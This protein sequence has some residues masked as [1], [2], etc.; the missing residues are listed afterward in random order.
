M[1]V[2]QIPVFL[3]T[4]PENKQNFIIYTWEPLT[5]SYLRNSG[6]FWEPG[7]FAGFLIIAMIFNY[8]EYNAIYNFKNIVFMLAIVTTFSTSGYAALFL[9]IVTYYFLKKLTLTKIIILSIIFISAWFAYFNFGFLN[10]K[11][12]RNIEYANTPLKLSEGRGRFT[13][14]KL[15]WMDI[16]KHPLIG[17]GRNDLTR[18]NYQG[19][20]YE[21]ENSRSNG[22]TDYI[23]KYGL[24]GFIIYFSLMYTS[25]R[26]Y[27]KNNNVD[28]K[29]AI[30]SL[31]II[32]TIGFS[33]GFFQQPAF[34]ILIYLFLVYLKRKALYQI[35]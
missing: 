25:F 1:L 17:R 29:V 11:I 33:Q 3:N 35:K 16:K 15:D 24:I 26:N 12:K 34:V 13:S 10:D 23:V 30:F 31:L 19:E 9:Y 27:C 28:V 20:K 4:D 18:F 2:S 21:L 22:I 5:E 6:P 8:I 7:A 32:F 14:A